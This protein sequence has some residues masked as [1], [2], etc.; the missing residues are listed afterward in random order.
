MV[1]HH[2]GPQRQAAPVARKSDAKHLKN[3]MQAGLQSFL[4]FRVP[5]LLTAKVYINKELYLLYNKMSDSETRPVFRK[6]KP[7][8]VFPSL[9]EAYHQ[10]EYPGQ[11]EWFYK[12]DGSPCYVPCVA[13]IPYT[14]KPKTPY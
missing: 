2:D 13:P 10:T 8:E 6:D 11:Y 5:T 4:S 12:D 9:V 1:T 7:E 3:A 14:T